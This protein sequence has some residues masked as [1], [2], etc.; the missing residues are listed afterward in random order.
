VPRIVAS[1]S[2]VRQQKLGRAWH[3]LKGERLVFGLALRQSVG[4]GLQLVIEN[5]AQVFFC[6]RIKGDYFVDAVE[7]FR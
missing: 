3:N 5:L 7:K 1:I 6:Q 2:T 4:H